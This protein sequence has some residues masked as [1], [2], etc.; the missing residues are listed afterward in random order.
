MRSLLLCSAVL[1]AVAFSLGAQESRATLTGTITDSSGAAVPGAKVSA[2]NLQTGLTAKSEANGQG[3]YVIPYLLP[4]QYKLLVEQTGFKSFEQS[5]IELRVSDRLEVNAVIP[6]GQ[7]TEKL[8]VT[9]EVPLVETETSSRG[10]VVDNMRVNDLPSNGRNPLQFVGLATGVQFAGSTQTYFRPFDTQLDFTIN[11]G[12]R[13]VNE[14]Q[15][16]GVP[17][18]AITYYTAEPQFAYAPPTEA[19]QEFKVQTNTYDAQYGRTSG[20]VIN[21]SIKSGTNQPHGAVYEYLRRTGLTANTFANNANGQPRPNRVQ[22][23]YG[24]ELDGPVFLPKLYHGRDKTFF[25]VAFEKYRD[26]QPQPGLGS[27]PTPDQRNGDFSS[28][29][30]ANG[31]PYTMYDPLTVAPNPAYD[32]SKSV[33]LSNLQYIRQ[34]FPNNKIPSARFNAVALNILKDIPLPNQ[35]GDAVTHLNNWFAGDA[36][37]ATDYYNVITRIDHSIND[38][39]RI[40]GRWDRNFR[41]GGKKNAYSWDTNAKQYTHSGRNNDGGMIDM[42]DTLNPQT[43]LSARIGFSR[44]VYSSVYNYQNLSYLGLP[45]T[46]LLQTPGKYPVV[47]FTN[48]I[49]TSVEDNDFSPSE[50]IS[51][52][53]SLVKVVGSH[54]IKFGGEYREVRYADVN[55]Q[56][57]EGKYNFTQAWTSSNPQVTDSASGNAIASFLLGDMASAQ[58][59]INAAPYLTWKYPVGF[60]QDDWKVTRRLAVNLGLRW[61][62]E[63]PVQERYNRQNRGFDFTAKSPLTVPGYNLVGGLLFAGVNGQPNGAFNP[64]KNAWQPRA[65]V[66]YQFFNDKPLVFRGGIGRYYLPTYEFGGSLGFSRVTTAQTSTAD[67]FPLATFSNPFPS[68]LLQ[69]TGSSLGLATGLG[70][71]ISFNDPTRRVPYV[72][73]FS[74]GLQY[75]VMRGLLVEASYVGSRTSD[76]QVSKNINALSPDQLALGTAY[77][78]TAVANPFYGILPTNVPQG[79]A[80]TIQRRNL[81]TPFPQFTSIT[82]GAQSLGRNWYNSLQVR[83]EKRMSHGLSVMVSYTLSKTIEQLAF[84]NAQDARPSRE[85]GTYDVP[86]RLVI[87]GIYQFPVGPHQKWLNHGLASHIIGGWSVDWNMIAQAGIPISFPSGYYINGDPKLSSGQSLNHWFNTSSSIWVLQPPD[88]LRTTKLRSPT[89]RQY[90]APQYDAT[91]IRNFRIR[92]G[93]EL[94]FKVSAFNI[95]NTPIFGAPNNS[96]TSSLFGV[97]PVTQINLPRDVELGFRY[98]F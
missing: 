47:S 4:G 56:N 1:L 63:M 46:S 30:Q 20:G 91:V 76:L 54:S 12:Q 9:A 80:P 22:D 21:L 95:T 70:D 11:G 72:W 93:H 89:I 34:A 18:N 7:V 64:T 55:V 67:Y 33:S 24:F 78:S 16:D 6:V 88:T 65:G 2:I 37:S 27:V 19:T 92:E 84:L 44:Y 59:T 86:Q 74:G 51:A 66:A 90:S 69:P 58:A 49:S 48:Y 32:P 23:Q 73:Q 36:N 57:S 71:T 29:F 28:T 15:I 14:I 60:F 42:V 98:R 52:Q 10:Q 62:E 41:D 40:F 96:P 87:S 97:V 81:L 5:P 25:M 8:T 83:V 77:L 39:L 45:V 68:G 82:E 38:R 26:V 13:G 17:D 85:I 50:N 75:E 61:D 53:A 94:Q 3:L 31:K 35:E 79:A 43:I